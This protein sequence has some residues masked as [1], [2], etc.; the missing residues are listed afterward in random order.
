MIEKS[1]LQ[2]QNTASFIYLFIYSSTFW[3]DFQVNCFIFI[4]FIFF[5]IIIFAFW[6]EEER[7]SSET[8]LY[9]FCTE[10]QKK[11]T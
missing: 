6:L 2:N 9:L 7:R 10:K 4:L 11:K 8:A 5:M 1:T 3:E